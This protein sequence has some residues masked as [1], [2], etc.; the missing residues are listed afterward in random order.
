MIRHT[1]KDLFD[2]QNHIAEKSHS[3]DA[4][5]ACLLLGRTGIL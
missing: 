4:T 2:K 3:N 5:N 1:D